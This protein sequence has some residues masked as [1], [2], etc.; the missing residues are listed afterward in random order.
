MRNTIINSDLINFFDKIGKHE[1]VEYAI[2]DS[3]SLDKTKILILTDLNLFY[4]I[5]EKRE[6][7]II[8]KLNYIKCNL[9]CMNCSDVIK[10]KLQCNGCNFEEKLNFFFKK[11]KIY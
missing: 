8:K 9:D 5:Q 3:Q 2:I 7:S 4:S 10:K 1:I 11:T 6:I